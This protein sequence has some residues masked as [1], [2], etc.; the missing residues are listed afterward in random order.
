MT[1]ATFQ[2]VKL[3][4]VTT[5]IGSG[6]TPRGGRDTYHKQGMP[7]IRSL[8]IYDLNFNYDNLA[9]I[10]DS[11]AKQLDNVSVE[12]DDVLLN[13][14]GASVCRCTS[15]PQKLVPARVNQHVSIIRA[16]KK[17]LLGN[18]LK[19]L[20]VSPLYKRE[21]YGLARTGATREALTKVDIENFEIKLP[22][23]KTQ[24]RIASVLSAYDDLIENN[25]KRIKALEEMA[26]L[27][28]TEWFVRFKFPGHEK[29]KMVESG[30]EYGEIPEGWEVKRLG[31]VTSLITKGTTPTTL[32][33]NFVKEGV[34]FIKIE[35]VGK[36][37]YLIKEK[38]AK[39]DAETH[40]LLKRSKLQEGDILFSIAGAIGRNALI[41]KRILPANTNQAL[42][43][44]RS[45]KMKYTFYL[46]QTI[47]SNSFYDFSVSRIV[48]T[49]QANVSLSVLS[50]AKIL[51][52]S[53]IILE[54]YNSIIEPIFK[55]ID[56]LRNKN[57]L[58][59]KMRDLL[60]PQLV[61]GRRELK[62]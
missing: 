1:M 31:D 28:Y 26:Q 44:I 37:G 13:I 58:I 43:I 55:S 33:K 8:N 39:I 16:D 53:E 49:A 56:I 32:K 60:I 27:L 57:S 20:L 45:A 51:F 29:V 23:I 40:E 17:S 59:S 15:V 35:S 50:S 25:E 14:T 2:R 54:Q 36:S 22:S 9:F 46:F 18:Y 38:F 19:Y 48:K 61:T 10:D 4:D 6:A 11:Q 52:P 30:T 47:S 3:G 5:K 41:T 21:L 34:N 62:N 42:A 12:K 24:T 7:L